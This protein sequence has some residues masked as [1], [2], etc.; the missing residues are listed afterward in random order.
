MAVGGAADAGSSS[1]GGSTGSSSKSEKSDKA[2]SYSKADRQAKANDN[3]SDKKSEQKSANGQNG[4]EATVEEQGQTLR[5]FDKVQGRPALGERHLSE[6]ISLQ[7]KNGTGS[8]VRSDTDM[9]ARVEAY[10]KDFDRTLNEKIESIDKEL[11]Q[12]DRNLEKA[13]GHTRRNLTQRKEKLTEQRQN[14]QSL[15]NSPDGE[16]QAKFE[17]YQRNFDQTVNDQIASVDQKLADIDQKLEKAK[18]GGPGEAMLSM[19]LRNKKG[20]LLQERANLQKIAGD[21]DAAL[22]A[23]K[24][25]QARKEGGWTASDVGHLV[26]DIVGL[27]PVVGEWADG[28]NA[29]WYFSEG[30]VFEGS[31]S[32][33]ATAPGLGVG[34]TIAKWGKKAADTSAILKGAKFDDVTIEALDVLRKAGLDGIAEV[35]ERKLPY[36][37]KLG[38]E[39]NARMV[40]LLNDPNL[41][42]SAATS[43]RLRRAANAVTEHLDQKDVI[44]AL[45]DKHGLPVQNLSGGTYD[46]L[47]EVDNGLSS[48]TNAR[49]AL[50]RQKRNLAPDDPAHSKISYTLDA[51]NEM[52]EKVIELRDLK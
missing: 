48:L 27:A 23:L 3:R 19:E 14:L 49:N 25:D 52:R 9:Q 36:L 32:L 38:V 6:N 39:T 22:K 31:M 37:G 42:L 45:R 8:Q 20:Q 40:K 7:T 21:P 13:A 26:L 17:S 18:L 28:L 33:A 30:R 46:H 44:G 15:A 29:A 4:R 41:D 1:R 16:R 34:A 12:V 2:E 47:L 24:A 43:A 50:I 51:I 5:D 10:Q 11:E 35:A